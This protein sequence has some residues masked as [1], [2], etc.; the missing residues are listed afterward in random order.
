MRDLLCR[1][2]GASP[3][4]TPTTGYT[5]WQQAGNMLDAWE[6]ESGRTVTGWYLAHYGGGQALDKVECSTRPEKG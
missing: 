6:Y 3:D 2:A 1:L 5:T 4:A